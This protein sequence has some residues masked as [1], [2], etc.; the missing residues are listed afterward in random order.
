MSEETQTDQTDKEL[1]F[2]KLRE[3]NEALE[4]QLAELSPLKV[5]QT[6]RAAGFDPDTPAGKALSRLADANS[7]AESV[8][9]LAAELGFEV[10]D[11]APVLSKEERAAQEFANRQADLGSVTTSDEPPDVATEVAELEAAGNWA[12]AGRRKLQQFVAANQ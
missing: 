1:N 2:E 12:E 3:K 11:P 8:K 10:V 4:A 9:N 5:A 7:D 6:V